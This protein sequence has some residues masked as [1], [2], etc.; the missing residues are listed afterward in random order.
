MP[1]K[2]LGSQ[3][4]SVVIPENKPRTEPLW[5][6]PEVD[7][8]TFSM[9][10]RFLVCPERFRL[11]V[12]EGLKTV[13]EFNPKIEYGQL[14]HTCEEAHAKKV[15]WEQPL[16]DYCKKLCL[17]YRNQQEG[18]LHWYNICLKQ[19]PVYVDYWSKH[20]D[21]IERQPLE[22]E[23]VF[24]VLYQLPSGRKVRIR[25]KRDSVDLIGK[26]KSAAVYLQENKTK[27]QINE[28]QITR[29]LTFDLQTMMYL[30]VLEYEKPYVQRIG[31][32]RYNVIRRDCPIRRHK[33]TKNKPEEEPVDF[34]NRLENDY[35]LANPEEW[36]M[37]WRV[38]VLPQD[39]RRFRKECLDPILE[40]LGQWYDEV[41][42]E[43]DPFTATGIHYRHPFGVY[44]SLNEGGSSDLD[45]YLMTGSEVGLQRVDSLFG[46]LT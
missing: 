34:Y 27:G 41:T 2:S 17:K 36:F 8:I 29:Q 35:F 24:D 28:Q 23:K 15:P 45:E 20:K 9:L 42:E 16:Q 10:S 1:P 11:R 32:V 38:E 31:G 13:D 39:I 26:G 30:T 19:F 18:V 46:E 40:R 7:G 4:K 3:L 21:V 33:A 25:G 12:I 5:K 6:G 44:N 37:R 14:W 22:Q 43:G